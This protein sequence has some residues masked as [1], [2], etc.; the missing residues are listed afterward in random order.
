MA[1]SSLS[2]L[3][4]GSDGV[5]SYD[6]IDQLK[7][8]DESAEIKPIDTKITDTKT[9][10]SD[11]S[12]LTTYTATLKSSISSLSDEVTYL[13]RSSSVTGEAVSVNASS[14]TAIQDFS[15][16][17]K[18]LA[19]SDIYQ[20]IAFTSQTSTFASGDDTLTLSIDGKDIAIDVDATTTVE[21]LR[22]MIN[23]EAGGKI[24]AS[25]LNVGGDEPY[26]LI[27]KSSDTGSANAI[28]I[29]STNT[30]ALDLGFSNYTYT[31]ATPTGTSSVSDT[32]TFNI[33]GTNH[34][35]TVDIG[36]DINAI[37]T[38]IESTLGN[39]L[40]A[41]VQ[42]GVLVLQSSDAN[43]SISSLNGTD[44]VFGLDAMEAPEQTNHLQTAADAKFDFNGISITRA[45]N[46]IDDLIV[47]VDITLQDTGKS[48][49][50]ITQDTSV[51]SDNISSFISAYNDL[52]SNIN[53]AIKYDADSETA[54]SLQGVSQVVGLKAA[55]NRQLLSV[56]DEGK[57]LA[58]YGIALNENGYLEVKESEFNEALSSN[59]Q[60]LE[61]FFRGQT[62]VNTTSFN[63]D[64]I[65]SGAIDVTSGDFSINGTDIVVSLNGT[66]LE[67]AQALKN[68]INEANIDG[69]TAY[70]D[71][72]NFSV[73][74]KSSSG[75]NIQVEGDSSKLA[76]LGFNASTVYGSIDVTEGFFSDFNSLLQ[77]YIGD[78]NS[79]LNLLSSSYENQL[80]SLQDEKTSTQDR[81]DT[82]YDMMATKFAAYDSIISKLNSQY[83]TLSMMID[84][85]SSDS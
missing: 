68:A 74:L 61:N 34:D 57:S 6:L 3:G 82:K 65:S 11:L 46:N 80:D 63:A 39:T 85:A 69:V 17:V 1:T 18:N 48:N 35:I 81:I 27:L 45:S 60:G 59:P 54:G 14:G 75:G 43:M 67:N 12:V 37:Q 28:D 26:R 52:M 47:G 49:V 10:Q 55:I 32:L 9:K 50:S 33:N 19:S 72:S 41:S 77:S 78:D 16:D 40:Q 58:D 70:L 20:S 73:Y 64:S 76:S 79:V 53:E 5:L 38:K 71:E 25:I 7:N 29:S 62:T 4:L 15:L 51:I 66:A 24:T 21:E 13:K 42:D 22:D 23:E 56:D 30:T 83:N 44:T 84:Q 2:S 8:A 31:G 36:D